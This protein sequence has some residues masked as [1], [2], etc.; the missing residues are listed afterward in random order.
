MIKTRS[1]SSLYK[2]ECYIFKGINRYFE[3]KALNIFFRTITH[4][5]G[6]I[7]N[8][9]I[10]LLYNATFPAAGTTITPVN[11]QLGNPTT[12][13]VTAKYVSSS[14]PDPTVGG[15]HVN[16]IIQTG[17]PVVVDYDGTLIIPSTTSQRTFYVRLANNTNQ[18]NILSINVSWWE[19]PS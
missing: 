18:S 7:T 3:R 9:T 10:D 1:I 14:A 15:T 16:S 2:I 6:A 12:S 19:L 13:V 11:S 4:M 8:T 5:G 17:G